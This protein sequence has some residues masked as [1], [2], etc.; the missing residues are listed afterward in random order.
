[1]RASSPLVE[2]PKAPERRASRRL[3]ALSPTLR[4]RSA[5]RGGDR[6]RRYLGLRGRC[7][8]EVEQVLERRGVS[9]APGQVQAPL[10]VLVL[11]LVL[12]VAAAQEPLLDERQ[13]RGVVRHLVRDV[14][15]PRK[16]RYGN[17]GHPE[18]EL[19]EVGAERRVRSGRGE[20]G[21]D[22]RRLEL[23]YDALLPAAGALA[24]RRARCVGALARID[25]VRI[26]RSAL[27]RPGRRDVI[28]EATVLVV[29]EEEDR[30]LPAAARPE[31][32]DDLRDECLP[33]ADVRGRMLV[34]LHAGD[35]E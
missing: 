28:V 27:S 5:R 14:A 32:C 2:P 15:G 25:A 23:A 19:I 6:R 20:A 24:R 12:A 18:P 13:H 11:L 10:A 4:Y 34:G 3:R 22:G 21:A 17:E 30:V 26:A 8:V 7:P 29:G 31:G 35:A 33:E 9:V 1:M 16:R